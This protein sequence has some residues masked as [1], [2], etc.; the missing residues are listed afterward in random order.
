MD[1]I[2]SQV[3]E[4]QEI[5]TEMDLAKSPNHPTALAIDATTNS[6]ANL[7]VNPRKEALK[8]TTLSLEK[9]STILLD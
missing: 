7:V 4:F 5:N 3:I 8:L 9:D 2:R 1:L 6:D